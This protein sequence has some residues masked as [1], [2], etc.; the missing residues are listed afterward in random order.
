MF[1]MMLCIIYYNSCILNSVLFT[2]M[3][4]ISINTNN[5]DIAAYSRSCMGERIT[6]IVSCLSI[7]SI[8]IFV[9][10][11]FPE[12][13]SIPRLVALSGIMGMDHS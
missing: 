5:I 1:I 9:T 10:P 8:A 12:D 6:N 7:F 4:M 11:M 13:H 3:C 2:I